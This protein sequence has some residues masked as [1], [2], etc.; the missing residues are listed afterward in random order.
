MA[1]QVGPI[2]DELT[3]EYR[4]AIS[5]QLNDLRDALARE[6]A[7]S[8][9]QAAA[10]T[11]WHQPGRTAGRACEP[12][13]ASWTERRPQLSCVSTGR[14][15][16]ARSVKRATRV[17]GVCILAEFEDAAF[18]ESWLFPPDLGETLAG[19]K[20]PVPGGESASALS[21]ALSLVD[22]PVRLVKADAASALLSI[23][24]DIPSAIAQTWSGG[25]AAHI[26]RQIQIETTRR[27]RSHDLNLFKESSATARGLGEEL[28][29]ILAD[30]DPAVGSRCWNVSRSRR[31]QPLSW[32]LP[33]ITA[34][35]S[36]R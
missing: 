26:G 2:L 16:L 31:T 11:A 36:R 28:R 4:T 29:S 7:R 19:G 24:A 9:E 14:E 15:R 30:L 13:C 34:A 8:D 17:P 5:T 22:A 23:D 33:D 1:K 12:W 6:R 3:Q 10:L 21:Y 35:G 32:C 20:A 25:L 27:T 18:W